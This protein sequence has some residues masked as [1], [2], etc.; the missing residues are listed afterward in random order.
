MSFPKLQ[1]ILNQISSKLVLGFMRESV[2]NIHINKIKVGIIILIFIQ[3]IYGYCE[4]ALQR[5]GAIYLSIVSYI[6]GLFSTFRA[7]SKAVADRQDIHR[8][9]QLADLERKTIQNNCFIRY[10]KCNENFK[11]AIKCSKVVGIL[12]R[13]G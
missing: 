9:Q 13:F 7:Q 4:N 6:L 5:L 12:N 10:N 11:N 3:E 1:S 8:Y 2:T